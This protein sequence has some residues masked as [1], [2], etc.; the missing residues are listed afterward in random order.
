M[1]SL[2]KTKQMVMA[3]TLM[4]KETDMSLKTMKTKKILASFEENFTEEEKSNL[5][6][7]INTLVISK[8]VDDLDGVK[9]SMKILKQSQKHLILESTK[10]SGKEANEMAKAK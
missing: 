2:S 9:W 1:V 4:Q 10:A 5:K 8:M 3:F 6:T 7:E